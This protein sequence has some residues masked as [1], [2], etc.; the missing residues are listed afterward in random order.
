M[1]FSALLLTF[2]LALPQPAEAKRFGGGGSFGKQ[3]S[4]PAQQR[5]APAQRQ[6]QAA[7][8][9][10]QT[11]Q[12][13]SGSAR[14]L[15]PMAGLAAGGML[16]WMFFG[17]GFEGIQF[18]DVLLFG[19]LG[20]GLYMLLKS[21]RRQLAYPDA[22]TESEKHDIRTAQER[23]NLGAVTGMSTREAQ[24]TVAPVIGS[25]LSVYAEHHVEAPAWFDEAGFVEQ[26]KQHFVAV[27]KAWDQGDASEIESYC[28][29][30]LFSQLQALM[31]DIVVEENHTEVD[32]LYTELVDQS[33]EDDYFVV[34]IRFSGF[35]KETKDE[36]AHA[37]NEVW[38]IR[39]LAAGE[40]N[41]QIAGIQQIQ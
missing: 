33:F 14:W 37:F 15:G 39:R 7:P 23:S 18:M 27:Q 10:S 24:E 3:K 11:G 13:A 34:S 28:T 9:A 40:G 26:A 31:D 16:A 2:S 22:Q 20:F 4:M 25:G 6:Q 5:Q 21:R 35:I 30:M 32:T 19:L 36:P 29:P 41:W 8:P 12:A 38:H 1:S 17:E